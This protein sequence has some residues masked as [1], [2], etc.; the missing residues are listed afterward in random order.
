M[1]GNSII[2]AVDRNQRNLELL[3]Q[4]F[5]K[6]GYQ[7]IAA[8]S[9]EE[10]ARAID[11]PARIGMALVDISGFDRRIWDCCEQLRSHQIPF[12]IL[13]PKQS[14]AIQHESFSHGARSILV[15]PLIV[16]DLLSIV[17]SL[18]GEPA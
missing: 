17:H 18:L 6:E 1:T 4:F 15:K 9:L 13:S 14:A 3:A 8:D 7:T 16:R 5:N 10:V 11:E 12:L 2:L